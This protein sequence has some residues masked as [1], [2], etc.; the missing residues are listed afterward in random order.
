MR[1]ARNF[2][3]AGDRAAWIVCCVLVGLVFALYVAV[4][5]NAGDG[6]PVMPVDDAYIHFQYARQIARGQFYAYNPGLPA[7]SGATSFLYP[8]VLAVGYVLGFQGL[9]LG[10]WAMSIGALALL[11]AAWAVYRLTRLFGVAPGLAALVMS[12][13]IFTG[14]VSWH[15]MSGMETGLIVC[16]TLWTF[17]AFATR[18]PRVF[19]GFA[20]LLALTRPEGGIMTLIAVVLWALR[21]I[22]S[23]PQR[24]KGHKG[25]FSLRSWR[26]GGLIIPLFAI[27]IQPLVN[28]LLTGSISA[29]GNQAKSL[30]GIIPAYPDVIWGRIFENFGRFWGELLTGGSRDGLWY[31]PLGIGLLALAG[32]FWIIQRHKRWGVFWLMVGWLLIVSAAISTLDTAFWHFKRYQMPLLALLFPL[33][34]WGVEFIGQSMHRQMYANIS[35]FDLRGVRVGILGILT[36][37]A[38]W[39]VWNFLNY[40]GLNT[41]NVAAQPL[42][43]ARWINANTPEDAVIAV[44]DVG[45]T[46]YIGDRTT[47]D[48]VGLTT[49]NAAEYWRN[50]PGAVGEFLIANRP[51]YLAAYN[52]AR[53][54]NYLANTPIYRDLLAGFTASFD[55]R[56]NVALGGTFQG[57]YQ[58]N[59]EASDRAAQPQQTTTLDYLREM[60]L[61]DEINVANLDSER[62]HN[63]RWSDHERFPGFITEFYGLY[64]LSGA[65]AESEPEIFMDGGRRINGEEAFTLK[66]N[67]DQDLI[68]ITRVHPQNGGTYDVYVNG[69]KIGTRVL[70]TQPGNWLEISTLIPSEFVTDDSTE[71]RIVPNTPGGHYQPYYHWAYQ[72]DY[73]PEPPLNE[74]TVTYQD[75]AIELRSLGFQY[76]DLA[77]SGELWVGFSWRTSSGAS[78]DYKAFVH[79]Y[80]NINEPPVAQSD[81][82]PGTGTLPPGNWLPGE[83][84]DEILVDVSTLSAGTYAIAIGLY[85]PVTN[86]RLLPTL[87]NSQTP[88]GLEVILDEPGHRLLI[89]ALTIPEHSNDE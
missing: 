50:G 84:T 40:Y 66:T 17:Y 3:L 42:V 38:L 26:L 18:Q 43:M 86:E 1:A 33:A 79:V 41:Q 7:T 24:R 47:L 9:N 46:R 65:Q 14:S 82:R 4:S 30:F 49:P 75:G 74:P 76:D 8:Y 6:Q 53:G 19:I 56:Y 44:H 37:F 32:L 54:L 34:G 31:L 15:F 21:E 25:A 13:F 80:S 78:G 16:F 69:E 77:G 51:D 12:A 88:T 83:I 61:V 58:P 35:T 67:L 22:R 39:T 89:G 68:L 27:G 60:Q 23:E 20:T 85:D 73:Q 72:G 64:Y 48:M 28:L 55:L 70:F 45:T 2:L 10:L 63:Y 59:W 57:V 5:L 71:I 36:L 87:V 62:E 81:R 11:G 29:S 52:D